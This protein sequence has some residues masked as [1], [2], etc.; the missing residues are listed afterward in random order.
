MHDL[1]KGSPI[2]VI[3]LFTIPLLIGSFFQLAYNFAD[4]MIVGQTLG[5]E[6]FAS[7]GATGSLTFL[8]LGFAQGLT[9]GLTIVTAQKFGAKDDDGIRKSFVHGV[10]YSLMTSLVLTALAL[11]FLRPSLQ[12]MRTP[13]NL[14]NHAQSFLTA[15]YGGMIFTIFFNYLSNVLRSLGN[16]KTPLI[17]LIIASIINVILDFIFILNFQMGVFGAGLATIIAQAFSVLYLAI[18]IYRKVPYFHMHLSDWRLDSANLKKH[19]QLGFP[20]GFQSSIIAIG[21]IILQISLN[22]LG[23]DAIAA[24]AIASKTDQLAMLPMINLGLAMST[25]TAQNYGAKEYKRILQGLYRTIVIAILWAIFF[26]AILIFFNR[27]FSG[28]FLSD[29][30]QAVYDLALSYYVI[31]GV[32][33]WVL[34][35]LFVTRSFIQGLGKGLV[36]TLAGIMELVMRAGIATVGSIYFGFSG[37]AASNPAAWI[38]ALL[39]LLP[40][41]FIMR[42]RL[43]AQANAPRVA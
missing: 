7:V 3:L 23:T 41:T 28:L 1:T 31:N 33:Y 8:I 16:S 17:A 2:K 38:G 9:A 4:S 13:D 14:I 11:I 20:M 34:S 35:I 30:S 6:A 40:S 21:A 43:K 5:K 29:G 39:V 18:Y 19:A 22:Q 42:K 15:I 36:P 26:A 37:I 27:F 32:L 25:F 24:Q 10:F 12:L